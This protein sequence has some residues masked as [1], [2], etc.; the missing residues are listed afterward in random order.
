MFATNL[1]FFF[2]L[3]F[4]FAAIDIFRFYRFLPTI[5][6]YILQLKKIELMA[7]EMLN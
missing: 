6:S 4:K 3:I 2:R 5:S 7:G 1:I